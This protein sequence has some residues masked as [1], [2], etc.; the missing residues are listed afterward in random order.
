M[1]Q[2]RKNG[3]VSANLG[4]P[5]PIHHTP[6]ARMN[7]SSGTHGAGFDCNIE[8]A[9][10]K[11]VVPKFSSRPAQSQDFRVGCRIIQLARPVVGSRDHSSVL[12]DDGAHG[13]FLLARCAL[14]L[15]QSQAHELLVRRF[16]TKCQVRLAHQ[17]IVARAGRRAAPVVITPSLANDLLPA[18]FTWT[19]VQQSEPA[20]G[21]IPSRAQQAESSRLRWRVGLSCHHRTD[22]AYG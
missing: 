20:C 19:G 9:I 2:D 3:T 13:N 1:V 6:E 14:C 16:N 7:N 15:A 4:V 22:E 12:D 8:A 17:A 5:R 18:A 11:A 21:F 10:G